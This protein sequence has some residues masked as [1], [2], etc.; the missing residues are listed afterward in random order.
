MAIDRDPE[1]GLR[2][3]W[4]ERILPYVQD[5]CVPTIDHMELTEQATLEASPWRSL[6]GGFQG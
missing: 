1:A 3:L 6:S 2:A 4:R 5:K